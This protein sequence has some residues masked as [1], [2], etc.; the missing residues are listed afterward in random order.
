MYSFLIDN[1]KLL[2]NFLIEESTKT[3]EETKKIFRENLINDIELIK[4]MYADF[5][6]IIEYDIQTN[7][8]TKLVFKIKLELEYEI[9]N[10]FYDIIKELK[11]PEITE[12]ES[13]Y[14]YKNIEKKILKIPYYLSFSYIE[15]EININLYLFWIKKDNLFSEELYKKIIDEVKDEMYFNS[16][17]FC[18]IEFIKNN[19]Q[20]PDKDYLLFILQE[21]N[22]I[23]ITNSKRDSFYQML[24]EFYLKR[25]KFYS[26]DHNLIFPI[27]NKFNNLKDN[28]ICDNLYLLED[29]SNIKLS[30]LSPNNKLQI[31]SNLEDNK[32]PINLNFNISKIKKRSD[33]LV[34]N[35]ILKKIKLFNCTKNE[36]NN[37]I[38]EVLT[39]YDIFF[40]LGGI[41]G[42]VIIDR[43]SS[44]QAHAIKINSYDDVNKYSDM[45]LKNNKIQKATHNIM[46]YRY[47]LKDVLGKEEMNDNKI[48]N[49]EKIDLKK[50]ISNKI[51]EGFED[52]GE[53]GAG[54]RL[55][56]ILQKMKIYNV[57]VI[58]SR[59]FGGTL[60]GNDRFK[61]I[62][63]AAKC[64]L[65][66]NKIKFDYES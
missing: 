48:K 57:Y 47:V 38:E 66:D 35:S 62:N 64:L 9:N 7:K 50:N 52:D 23:S 49:K 2:S 6:E 1:S 24:K 46:A 25:I 12:N 11:I 39:E 10:N 51:C 13:I 22:E 54:S 27:E 45:L 40:A 20:L 41:K 5:I 28:I 26:I 55:L 42:E 16:F 37:N 60:L 19:I 33:Q 61:Y 18:L 3:I 4:T 63:D 44:F 17:F 56:G 43:G 32:T 58:V 36:I 30:N 14:S 53:V 29:E 34:G 31:S 65:L 21:I 8:N 15:K 59:W